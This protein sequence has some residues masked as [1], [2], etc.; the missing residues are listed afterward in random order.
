MP[1]AGPLPSPDAEARRRWMGL[2]ARATRE[3]LEEAWR[4]LEPA[5]AYAFLRRPETGLAMVRGRTGGTGE[6]FNLGEMTLSRCAV[7]LVGA[8]GL[9]FVAGRDLRHAELAAVFDA[10]LQDPIRRATIET[11]LVAGIAH[12]LA[13]EHATRMAEVAATRVNFFTLAREA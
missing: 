6:P 9:S 10:L 12:R 2:L 8:T 1:D 13:G 5:P 7:R 3:E 11:T 4:S